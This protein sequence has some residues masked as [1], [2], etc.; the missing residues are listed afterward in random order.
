[1]FNPAMPE[2]QNYGRGSVDVSQL[3]SAAKQIPQSC[4]LR[5]KRV[6]AAFN[7]GSQTLSPSTSGAEVDAFCSQVAFPAHE[8]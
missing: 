1:M 8:Q 3:Y 2:R 7:S 5:D 4:V 6:L